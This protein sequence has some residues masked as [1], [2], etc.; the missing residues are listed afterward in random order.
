MDL[1]YDIS[2]P[3]TNG[4]QCNLFFRFNTRK[5]NK[6]KLAKNKKAGIVISGLKTI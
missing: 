2:N 3:I 1:I 4:K 6:H 5:T